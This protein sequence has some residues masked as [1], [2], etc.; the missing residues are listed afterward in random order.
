MVKK[1]KAKESVKPKWNEI[2]LA[3]VA[4]LSL[5]FNVYQY[6]DARSLNK[7]LRELNQTGMELSAKNAQLDSD[8][9]ALQLA[10]KRNALSIDFENRYL[11]ITG[12]GIYNLVKSEIVFSSNITPPMAISPG[13]VMDDLKAYIKQE[14]FPAMHEP[15]TDE[16]GKGI[17]LRHGLLLLRIYNRG[18]VDAREVSLTIKWRDFPNTRVDYT[19]NKGNQAQNLWELNTG[20]WNTSTIKL[21]DIDAGKEIIVPL[22]HVLG[23]NEYFGRVNIPEHLEWLSPINKQ[24]E[25]IE[26]G[27]MVPNDQW[28]YKTELGQVVIVAQ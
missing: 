21:A 2:V 10:E 5:I 4:L 24:S 8:L 7:K 20:G 1:T 11:I 14:E 15:V 13:K 25:S 12:Q 18:K 27:K 22:A 28:L 9:K 26:I 6:F 19:D 3:I 23:T 17:K 16:E